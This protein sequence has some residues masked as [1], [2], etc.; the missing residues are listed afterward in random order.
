M[1]NPIPYIIGFLFAIAF[2]LVGLGTG[3]INIISELSGSSAEYQSFL[4]RDNIEMSGSFEDFQQDRW[5]N[6][7]KY[8]EGM[9]P[10]DTIVK[11]TVATTEDT[12]DS[13]ITV[14]N[15]NGEIASLWL[16]GG[17]VSGLTNY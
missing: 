4:Q 16:T 11:V 10:V 7:L 5:E 15:V 13:V 1:K 6:H 8:K 2:I 9:F 12:H 17:S 3:A 14:T